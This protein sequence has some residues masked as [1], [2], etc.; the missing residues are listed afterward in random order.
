METHTTPADINVLLFDS[1]RDLLTNYK[2]ILA[3]GASN[4][5]ETTIMHMV[6]IIK[7]ELSLNW[8]ELS[9]E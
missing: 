2:R 5:Q 7:D 6:Q 8:P 3:N 4:E 9:D 1:I